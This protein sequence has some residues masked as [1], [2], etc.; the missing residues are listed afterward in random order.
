MHL[1]RLRLDPAGL[2]G[3]RGASLRGSRRSLDGRRSGRCPVGCEPV[4]PPSSSIACPTT[5]ST[6][7]R[8]SR[9]PFGLPGRFRNK[10]VPR[11]AGD[12]P[13]E[14]RHGR[15]VEPD[16]AH[17]LGQTRR[18]ALED[19]ARRLGRDVARSEPGAAGGDDES[20]RPA[21][22]DLAQQRL[23]RG[24]ARRARPRAGRL[25]NPPRAG[26]SRRRSPEP[27]ARVP[28]VT[29]SETVTT[30]A[31][32]PGRLMRSSCQT[33]SAPPGSVSYYGVL[34]RTTRRI[35]DARL[36]RSTRGDARRGVAVRGPR[37]PASWRLRA[38]SPIA[39]SAR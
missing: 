21:V 32:T 38:T 10:V 14:G 20:E 16:P 30:A 9:T 22:R 33:G 13:R 24:H 37:R 27:S 29:P 31:R 7:S 3:K 19:R 1:H 15:R 5:G 12:R 6:A 28:C 25:R 18:L 11:G 36:D 17:E 34:R 2:G 39:S 23:D 35:N 8:L 4:A 26:A